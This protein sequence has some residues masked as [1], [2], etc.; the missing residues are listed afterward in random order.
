M[1]TIQA[2]V[3][4]RIHSKSHSSRQPNYSTSSMQCSILFLLFTPYA[5]QAHRTISIKSTTFYRLMPAPI[6][7][8]PYAAQKR[9]DLLSEDSGAISSIVLYFLAL[10]QLFCGKCNYCRIAVVFCSTNSFDCCTIPR[11]GLQPGPHGASLSNLPHLVLSG[12]RYY[13]AAH[14]G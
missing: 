9:G 3:S 10:F 7:R 13:L 5:Q 6:Y 4:A 12:A 14:V 1:Q 8:S 2:G 11:P